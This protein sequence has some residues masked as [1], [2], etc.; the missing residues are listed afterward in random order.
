MAVQVQGPDGQT[1]LGEILAGLRYKDI[2]AKY[3]LSRKQVKDRAA[4]LKRDGYRFIPKRAELPCAGI[5]LCIHC[6]ERKP[7]EDFYVRG[8]RGSSWCKGCI[9]LGAVMNRYGITKEE[10]ESLPSGDSCPLCLTNYSDTVIPVIDHDHATGKVRGIICCF[11][12]YALGRI[13]D[14]EDTALRMHEY[15]KEHGATCQ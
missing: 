11:C 8:N 10:F 14:N 2:A 4:K 6:K 15:L 12:N 13:L 9:R 5:K 3:G 1:I 7:I